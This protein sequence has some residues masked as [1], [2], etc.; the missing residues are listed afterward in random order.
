MPEVLPAAAESLRVRAARQ[1]QR[2]ERSALVILLLLSV[3][4]FGGGITWGLPSR[5]ADP[6]LFGRRR[7]WTGAEILALTG[8][9][10]P[11][12]DKGADVDRDPLKDRSHKLL[13][14]QTDRDRAEIVR[15]YRLFSYQPD[16]MVTL[17]ALAQM[18]PGAGDL[19]PRLYQYGGLWV[20]AVGGLLKA[21]SMLHVIHLT[22]DLA[23]YLDHPEAFAR[24]YVVARLYVVAWGMVGAWAVR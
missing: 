10:E 17:M 2:R 12:G 21:S 20:Y 11:S 22:A 1:R 23:Y 15:R 18:R 4:V 19:D 7:P 13:I 3:A 8:P 9:R 14:N 16:E 24:F 5:A 6:F